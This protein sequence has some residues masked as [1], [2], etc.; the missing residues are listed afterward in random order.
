MKYSIIIPVYDVEKYIARC[1]QSLVD[2]TF[3]DF[4]AIVV[5]DG[6]PDDSQKIIDEF[7]KNDPRFKG[8]KKENGGLS[9]AR[10]YGVGL[11]KGEYI[12]FL[13]SD[14]YFDPDL[15]SQIS[16]AGARYDV[17]RYFMRLVNESGD[18]LR[19][20]KKVVFGPIG[21]AD[22]LGLELVETACSYAYKRSFWIKNNFMFTRGRIHE[23]FG[24]IPFVLSVA[25]QLYATP[26][27]GYNYTQRASSITG[28]RVSNKKRYD[29]IMFFC[30]KSFIDANKIKNVKNKRLYQDFNANAVINSSVLLEKDDLNNHMLEIRKL[31]IARLLLKNSPK[32]VAKWILVRFCP[33]LITSTIRKSRT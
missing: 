20:E 7:V 12:L 19:T 33:I 6:S 18:T 28:G 11:A 32:K 15:L 9:D 1:L 23:D 27:F 5:N 2:Q 13:D 29:D 8:Y 25:E 26:V 30:K 21:L 24:L 31:G 16:K 22:C 3:S 4:E 10:N 14:D 17:V